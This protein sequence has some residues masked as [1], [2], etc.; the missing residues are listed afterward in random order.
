[1]NIEE[2][3]CGGNGQEGGGSG[4]NGD[5]SE[6]GLRPYRPFIRRYPGPQQLPKIL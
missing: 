5:F 4:W 3:Q 2:K 6:E 1:M